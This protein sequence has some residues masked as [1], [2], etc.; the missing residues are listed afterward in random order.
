MGGGPDV[1]GELF[2]Q[3]VE[4]LFEENRL[5]RNGLVDDGRMVDLSEITM[6]VAL[7]LGSED[8][9]VPRAASLPFLDVV[10]SENIRVFDVLTG[11]VRTFVAPVAHEHYWPQVRDRI[12]ARP[13]D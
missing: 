8:S 9:F 13:R 2:R 10:G 3:F 6:P 7:V 11:H 1:P 12:V 4:A 5:T